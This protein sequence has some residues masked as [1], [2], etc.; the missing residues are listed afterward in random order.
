MFACRISS[1]K[2]LE[3]SGNIEAHLQKFV[4]CCRHRL[5]LEIRIE[6]NPDGTVIL[7]SEHPET[8]EEEFYFR[9][10]REDGTIFLANL[11]VPASKR[12]QGIG[13]LCVNW[14]KRAAGDIG[15]DEVVLESYPSAVGFWEKMGFSLKVEQDEF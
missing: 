11:K 6:K 14:L 7:A 13:A 15:V 10:R 12:G 3:A 1:R 2:G 4:E 9:F 5:G 8:P